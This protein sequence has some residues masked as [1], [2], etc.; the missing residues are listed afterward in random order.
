M[1]YEITYRIITNI[2]I[3]INI[4][5]NIKLSLY[6]KLIVYSLT[7]WTFSNLSMICIVEP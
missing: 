1:K 2:I 6:Q 7:V 4:V 5:I 3:V